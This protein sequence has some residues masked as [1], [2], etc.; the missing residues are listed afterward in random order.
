MVTQTING[1]EWPLGILLAGGFSK[2]F[3]LNKLSQR[4][5]GTTVAEHSAKVLSS[6]CARS[7]EAGIGLTSLPQIPDS[8]G[9]GPLAAIS[10]AVTFLRKSGDLSST[11]CALVL[12]ADLPLISAASLTYL[13]EWPGY[14]SVVPVVDGRAQ[15]LSA[16]WSAQALN[17]SISLVEADQLRV[18]DALKYSPTHWLSIEHWDRNSPEFLDVDTPDE[19]ALARIAMKT[20]AGI[21][22]RSD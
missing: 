3:G 6:V 19:L 1:R 10:Q 5:D 14:A 20:P 9:R 4:L 21:R 13:A 22:T 12:A 8:V 15:F 18:Q 17:L 2:R 11:Q 16:R 7:Y